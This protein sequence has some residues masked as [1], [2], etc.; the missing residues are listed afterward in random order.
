MKRYLCPACNVW[1][2][3]ER[4]FYS[5]V[6]QELQVEASRIKYMRYLILAL[7]PQEAIV[8]NG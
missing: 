6:D 2:A 5:H 8:P 7:V 4:D 3:G 1:F